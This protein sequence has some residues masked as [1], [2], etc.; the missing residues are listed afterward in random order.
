[1]YLQQRTQIQNLLFNRNNGRQKTMDGIFKVM[2]EKS[3]CQTRILFVA[4]TTFKNK[5][6]IKILSD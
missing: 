2:K 5:V 1:M 6:E 3:N 4:K